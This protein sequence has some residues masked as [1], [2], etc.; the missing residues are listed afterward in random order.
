MK[1]LFFIFLAALQLT[2]GHAQQAPGD[3][4]AVRIWYAAFD[5]HDPVL[6]D[7]ILSPEWVD[8]PAMP[9][10]AAGPAG[11]KQVLASIEQTFPDFRITVKDVLQDGN[12]VVVRSEITATQRGRFAGHAATGHKIVIMAIDIHEFEAGKIVRTWHMEDWMSGLRQLGFVE[13]H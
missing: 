2:T 8:I 11:A 12:K 5:Q 9:D 7:R 10:Q 13:G 6:I 1:K 3:K 4:E